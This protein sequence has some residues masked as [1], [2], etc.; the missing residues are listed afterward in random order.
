MASPRDR[1]LEGLLAKLSARLGCSLETAVY[2]GADECDGIGELADLLVDA[3]LLL[4]AEPA[5]ALICDGCERN[6]VMTV[7]VAP[8]TAPQ[9][10]PAFIVC[11]KRDDIG[12][13]PVAPARLRRW[14]F[15]LPVLAGALVRVLKTDREAVE[16]DNGDSWL[17]GRANI[18]GSAIPMALTRSAGTVSTRTQLA[19]LLVEPINDADRGRWITVASGFS[20]RDG[21][22]VSRAGVLRAALSER[23]D[24]PTVAFEVRFD[25][26][27]V[28]LIDRI[29]GGSR[30]ISTPRL[31]SQSYRVFKVLCANSGQ[32]FTAQE[33]KEKTGL[34]SLKSL[35]KIPEN[36]RFTGNLKRLFFDV[37]KRGIRFRREV[38]SGQLA[39]Y[40]IDP[41]TII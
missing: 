17:L 29:G 37:S 40:H 30:T 41:K 1:Q 3:G 14:I 38:T 24:D 7:N 9:T 23:F 26:G 11:D 13:V 32:M 31:G 4:P 21:R 18:G 28:M 27:E 12:R 22:L 33:L 8:A 19:I 35:H 10:R 16:A 34:N 5:S 6:C 25:Y 20:L 2:V 15:S 39:I 36:L